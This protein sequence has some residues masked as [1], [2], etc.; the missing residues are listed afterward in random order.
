MTEK[1]DA[2]RPMLPNGVF[3]KRVLRSQKKKKKWPFKLYFSFFNCCYVLFAFPS[4]WS[5]LFWSFLWC[6]FLAGFPL[7][8]C[9][10]G[11]SLDIILP[12]KRR[13]RPRASDGP[14]RAHNSAVDGGFFFLL[15]DGAK[16]D[17]K[18][19]KERRQSWT[20]HSRRNG[21]R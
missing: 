2:N 9:P 11:P 12:K 19:R 18:E 6:S 20:I 14:L 17:D 4:F 15:G 21:D 7:S 5:V 8:P 16:M 10:C 1:G 3:S 13:D